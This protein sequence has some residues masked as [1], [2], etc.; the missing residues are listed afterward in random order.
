MGAALQIASQ[1]KYLGLLF[2]VRQPQHKVYGAWA[3]LGDSMTT[4]VSIILGLLF[5]NYMKCV[6][7]PGFDMV[8][9]CGAITSFATATAAS[10]MALAQS[11]LHIFRQVS[12]FK[13]DTAVST[14]QLGSVWPDV[15][16]RSVGA[17]RS[18]LLECACS[19][20]T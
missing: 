13:S 1:V 9:S 16:P 7:P 19:P 4:A 15:T 20:A 17:W 3:L 11:H 5:R 14:M 6:P 2:I 18:H 12:Y 10:S 8:V